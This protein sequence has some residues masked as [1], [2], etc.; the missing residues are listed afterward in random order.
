MIKELTQEQKSKFPEYVKKWTDIGR[1]TGVTTPE[2]R[3]KAEEIVRKIY[4]I[5]KLNKNVEIV[6]CTSPEDALKK[7]VKSDAARY[8]QGYAGWEGFVDFFRTEC[9]LVKETENSLEGELSKNIFMYFVYD[10]KCFLVE[11]P[12]EMNFDSQNRA[13]SYNR[14]S[15]LWSDGSCLCHFSGIKVPMKYVKAKTFTKEEILS[16]KNADIRREMVAKIGIIEAEKILGSVCI[17]RLETK[18]GGVYEL[19]LIDYNNSGEERPYLKMK[20]P[21]LENM[22]H[23]EGIGK[24]VKTV[25]EAIMFRW[26]LKELPDEDMISS[27][28]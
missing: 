12:I 24:D 18:F 21:S 6:W 20:N 7:G 23:I 19:L 15:H 16:E 9:G 22:Y 14:P 13:H 17:D 2:M 1:S 25:K 27:V 11:K 8:V 26:D 3:E 4:E 10:T 28:T 5:S